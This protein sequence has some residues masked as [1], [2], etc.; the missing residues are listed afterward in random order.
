MALLISLAL[1]VV[2]GVLAQVW[3]G[4]IGAVYAVLTAVAIFL[5]LFLAQYSMLLH[6]PHLVDT[7]AGQ[8][9]MLIVGNAIGLIPMLIIVASLPK[10]RRREGSASKD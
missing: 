9:S 3:K 4:R 2:V 10:V 7:W 5:G 6:T 8:V 1:C